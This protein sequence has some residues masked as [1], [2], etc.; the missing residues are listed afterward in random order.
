MEKKNIIFILT[1]F[2]L[3]ALFL[4]FI[5]S[6][7]VVTPFYGDINVIDEG[8]SG[9]WVSHMLAGKHLYLDTYS[10]YGPFL[11]YPS[12]LL[13]KIFGQSIF[14]LR[15]YY[16]VFGVLFSLFV[17]RLILVKLRIPNVI[18]L[19]I[20]IV[21]L[22]IPTLSLRQSIGFLTIY[23]F[24][25][26]L[27]YKKG[28]WSFLSGLLIAI[29]F[30]VS[31]DAGI[32]TTITCFFLLTYYL[33]IEKDLFV[34]L[35]KLLLVFAGILVTFCLFFIWSFSEGW[36][37]AYINSTLSDLTA[38]SGINLPIGKSF[39]NP[40]Q[41]LPHNLS[42]IAWAK[43]I[44]S[45]EML[46]YWLYFFYITLFI[47]IFIRLILKKFNKE[48]LLII[49]IG[50]YGFLYST[51]LIGRYGHF[52]GMLAPVIIIFAYLVN[53]L[54]N[55]YKTTSNKLDR[56]FS[57]L[58]IFLIFLFSMRV[59]LIFRPHF[60]NISYAIKS[61]SIHKNNPDFVGN[62]QIS[63][64]QKNSIKI[65]QDF[66]DKNVGKDEKIFFFSNE[67]IMYLMVNRRNP[68]IYDL[69]EVASLKEKRM[70]LLNSLKIDETRYIIEDTK[71]WDLDEISNR[72][73]LPEVYEYIVDNYNSR[74][75]GQ[76]IIYERNKD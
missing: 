34:L 39:P 2:I 76:Y 67:P 5:G 13:A 45:K 42:L 62:I 33:I 12:Y 46:L 35:K 55:Q 30:L 37:F 9:A 31:A 65:I 48:D 74:R 4:L 54:I 22:I 1:F 19:F 50:I 17:A 58:I 56:I 70:E 53:I 36:F 21:L 59:V 63:S 71:A 6:G 41:L 10:A 20:F 69:P 40:I 51:V 14:I 73:R 61:V 26:A 66:V 68:S 44:V 60:S 16:L 8:L 3:A 24:Y 25:C 29:S 64:E 7:S 47:L 28:F 52:L 38:Y 49:S 32:F 23:V 43:Y 27:Q 72:R 11:I 15:I 57:V 75:L 18:Q